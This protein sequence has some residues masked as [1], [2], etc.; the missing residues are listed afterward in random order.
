MPPSVS[1]TT[2]KTKKQDPGT[3]SVSSS[4]TSTG[5]IAADVLSH[6]TTVSAESDF[7][8]SEVFAGAVS[9]AGLAA[10]AAASSAADLFQSAP[11]GP[12]RALGGGIGGSASALTPRARTGGGR[13]GGGFGAHAPSSPV[14]SGRV[15]SAVAEAAAEMA[16]EEQAKRGG[17]RVSEEGAGRAARNR[18]QQPEAMAAVEAVAVAAAAAAGSGG[19]VA[20]SPVRSGAPEPVQAVVS[21]PEDDDAPAQMSRMSAESSPPTMQGASLPARLALPQAMLSPVSP[22]TGAESSGHPR[23][24]SGA[25]ASRAGAEPGPGRV[26]DTAGAAG[27]LELSPGAMVLSPGTDSDR[28]STPSPRAQFTH[29]GGEGAVVRGAEGRGGGSEVAGGREDEERRDFSYGGGGG[30]GSGGTQRRAEEERSL[31]PWVATREGVTVAAQKEEEEAGSGEGGGEAEVDTRTV[32]I[33]PQSVA[34]S[35]AG[36]S[37]WRGGS[38]TRG[39]TAFPATT[40]TTPLVSMGGAGA[41]EAKG[42]LKAARAG[43]MRAL[44]ALDL[45]QVSQKKNREVVYV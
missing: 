5:R 30:S 3:G 2:K 15:V 20:G 22:P 24:S 35:G 29:P 6:P 25:G 34:S 14:R 42:G 40:T 12:P 13:G 7:S 27:F 32:S 8:L 44:G 31:S 21:S 16:E 28:G 23:S 17:R 10:A 33:S 41:D 1:P 9:P 26:I 11:P 19:V 45:M 36:S 37:L 4:S 43:K 38:E 18:R 39:S